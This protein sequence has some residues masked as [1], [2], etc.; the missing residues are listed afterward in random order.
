[1]TYNF[2]YS[3]KNKLLTKSKNLLVGK[4]LFKNLLEKN[5]IN[6]KYCSHHWTNKEKQIKDFKIVKKIYD[7]VVKD[8][9]INLNNYHSK[10]F[11]VRQWEILLFFF[12]HQYILAV[13]D[14]WNLIKS[15]KRKFKLKPIQ[16][17]SYEP[18]SFICE[19]SRNIV[20]LMLSDEWNDWVF[21]EIIKEQKLKYYNFKNIKKFLKI[22]RI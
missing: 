2:V 1:M 14:R 13:Y 7:E 3:E 11:S 8:L 12:L 19:E 15:I 6:I 16:L 22:K 5:Q 10:R 4:W 17:I 20:D 18:G 9:S 21:S